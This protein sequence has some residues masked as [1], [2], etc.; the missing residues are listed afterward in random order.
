MPP[1]LPSLA[2]LAA[3]IVSFTI[4]FSKFGLTL[5]IAHL[6]RIA[7]ATIAMA[8]LLKVFPEAPNTILL[9]AH[10][11]AGATAYLVTLAVLY[12]PS[13]FRILRERPQRSKPDSATAPGV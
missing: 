10:I 2:A 3:A 9:A 12:A 1:A 8:A 7:L 6:I 5:P 4:G 11:A 13:L